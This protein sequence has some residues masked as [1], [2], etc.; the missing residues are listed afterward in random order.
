M[1]LPYIFNQNIMCKTLR[2]VNN[3]KIIKLFNLKKFNPRKVSPII[4]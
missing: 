2:Y 4:M 1:Y 3:I